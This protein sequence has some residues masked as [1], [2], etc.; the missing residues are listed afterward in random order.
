MAGGVS[1]AGGV[2]AAALQHIQNKLTEASATVTNAQNHVEV[3][4]AT[5]GSGPERLVRTQPAA[6]KTVFD[7]IGAA[8]SQAMNSVSNFFKGL[9]NRSA[10]V[11]TPVVPQER[12]K[13][14]PNELSPKQYAQAKR[15]LSPFENRLENVVSALKV[16]ISLGYHCMVGSPDLR[17]AALNHL[18]SEYSTENVEM[19]L[20][21]LS[22]P[23]GLNIN[24]SIV[25]A[26]RSGDAMTPSS[27]PLNELNFKSKHREA[28]RTAIADLESLGL[29]NFNI[30]LSD[31]SKQNTLALN[32]EGK[33][34]YPPGMM[35]TL[36]DGIR[37]TVLN[38]EGEPYSQP[39]TPEQGVALKKLEVAMATAMKEI[40]KL[41]NDDSGGRVSTP[42]NIAKA[43]AGLRL[44]EEIDQLKEKM[45]ITE[46]Y[47][48]AESEAREA[49]ARSDNA[50]KQTLGNINDVQE[51]AMALKADYSLADHI[52]D[53][54]EATNWARQEYEIFVLTNP[55]LTSRE[56]IV[57]GFFNKVQ[58]D[59]VDESLHFAGLEGDN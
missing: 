22:S 43:T 49:V 39:L 8:V 34:A 28:M 5:L 11:Q 7:R 40:I 37:A 33:L 1:G 21:P 53:K 20:G 48:V 45:G 24:K 2:N 38:D 26:P 27:P 41:V 47:A 46:A 56:D 16:P 50:I 31:S 23:E 18:K 3:C 10:A 35:E 59:I 30:S 57:E 19:F 4:K 17:E 51:L 42:E 54:M 58:M 12:A 6:Q 55:E 29:A 32:D 25:G 13:A 52:S 14:S 44:R 15:V 36:A 9:T